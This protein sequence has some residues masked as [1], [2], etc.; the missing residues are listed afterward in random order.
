MASLL[1]RLV[2]IDDNNQWEEIS[3][4]EL[5][6]ELDEDYVPYS[7]KQ[8]QLGHQAFKRFKR[9]PEYKTTYYEKVR[10]HKSQRDSF[11]RFIDNKRKDPRKQLNSADKPFKSQGVYGMKIPGLM[12]AHIAGGDI[13]IVY[14][15]QNEG[16]EPVVYLYGFYTHDELGTGEPARPAIQQKMASNFSRFT[17]E[18]ARQVRDRFSFFF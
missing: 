5:M 1:E 9:S 3:F 18:S 6:L 12:H 13:S 7:G 11:I 15:V 16:S 10:P 4:D 8:K 14:R 17:F 2:E